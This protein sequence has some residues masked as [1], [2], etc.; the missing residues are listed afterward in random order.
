MY[1]GMKQ[2]RQQMHTQI[3]SLYARTRSKAKRARFWNAIGIG[4]NEAVS[5]ACYRN[6]RRLVS[7]VD[8]GI[9][10]IPVHRIIGS[11]DRSH[12]FD[13]QFR[14]ISDV[15]EARWISVAKAFLQGRPMPPLE[16][17]QVDQVYFV[18]DGNHRTSVARALG[19]DF[20][21]AHVVEVSLEGSDASD[22]G[23]ASAGIGPVSVPV[24]A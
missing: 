9:Q 20:I 14:P 8:R 19:Q 4:R 3:Q 2:N 18:V 10:V 1:P 23:Y 21:D 5:Y 13:E 12:E 6:Q 11:V 24:P 17:I 7:Q 16:V 15:T 22:D